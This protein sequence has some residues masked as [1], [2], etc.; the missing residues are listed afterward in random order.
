MKTEADGEFRAVSLATERTSADNGGIVFC[1]LPLPI[2]SILP[3]HVNGFFAVTSSR[4]HLF[5][6]TV[7]DKTDRRAVW[8]K[9][10]DGR[11]RERCLRHH[12]RGHCETWIRH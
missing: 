6:E 3:V 5:E 12:A 7:S 4:M 9:T 1:F 2:K 11:R 8:N 10:V